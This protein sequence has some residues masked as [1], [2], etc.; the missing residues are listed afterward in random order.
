MI[1]KLDLLVHE[2][3]HDAEGGLAKLAEAMDLGQQVLINKVNY[4]NEKN[5]L[6]LK[7]AL[8]M[9]EATGNVSILEELAWRLG[10]KLTASK[11]KPEESLLSAIVNAS[12]DHGK[13]HQTIEEAF[14]DKKITTRELK[15]VTQEINDAV[16]A[17]HSLLRT[18]EDIQQQQAPRE[19]L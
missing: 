11:A 10:H 16:E 5:K 2:T 12:A 4:N 17:L 18:I 7:E 19:S 15:N 1:D 14:I 3:A 13:V 6:S 8:T 9:M